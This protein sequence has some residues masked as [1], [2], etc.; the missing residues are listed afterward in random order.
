MQFQ[1]R[2]FW[3]YVDVLEKPQSEP[4]DK[5]SFLSSPLGLLGFQFVKIVGS[6]VFTSSADSVQPFIDTCSFSLKGMQL[7]VVYVLCGVMTKGIIDGLRPR[8]LSVIDHST[9][10]FQTSCHTVSYRP[11]PSDHITVWIVQIWKPL[12]KGKIHSFIFSFLL[13]YMHSSH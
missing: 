7:R 6:L 9:I 1:S 2:C 12:R 4:P 5:V 10:G 3:F 13:N 11:P 8:H